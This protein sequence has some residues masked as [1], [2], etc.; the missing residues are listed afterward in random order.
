MSD[1]VI[2]GP[3]KTCGQ[4]GFFNCCGQEDAK[5]RELFPDNQ[6]GSNFGRLNDNRHRFSEIIDL[7]VADRAEIRKA[8]PTAQDPEKYEMECVAY[9]LD[10][11]ST[12]LKMLM[13]VLDWERDRV[14]RRSGK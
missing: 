12:A 4:Q 13:T 6:K 14:A 8:W 5:A 2:G 11:L 3:C 7:L 9:R 1:E 10:K